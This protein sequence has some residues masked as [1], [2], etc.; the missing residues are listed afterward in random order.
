MGKRGKTKS[1]SLAESRCA[2]DSADLNIYFQPELCGFGDTGHATNGDA[3]LFFQFRN[4]T[5]TRDFH[6]W[7]R[8]IG[9]LLNLYWKIGISRLNRDEWQVC[10]WWSLLCLV[11]RSSRS[12]LFFCRF[13]Q[14]TFMSFSLVGISK[15][16]NK[17]WTKPSPSFLP[18]APIEWSC[19]SRLLWPLWAAV[20]LL[21]ASPPVLSS[22][23]QVLLT[24]HPLTS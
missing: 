18:V 4:E 14:K 13:A 23:P 1:T 2:K 19:R 12:S 22:L 10:I 17:Q 15:A 6:T 7:N 9:I 8:E 24:C 21:T 20:W 16:L 5:K 11:N 3:L